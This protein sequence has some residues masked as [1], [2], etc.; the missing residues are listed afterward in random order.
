VDPTVNGLTIDQ[1]IDRSLT[2][3]GIKG[4]LRGAVTGDPTTHTVPKGGGSRFTWTVVDFPFRVTAFLGPVEA[5]Y[6]IGV[7]ITLRIVDLSEDVNAGQSGQTF[8]VAA[9]DDLFVYVRNQGVI[10]GGNTGTILVA[11]QAY[12]VFTLRNGVVYGKGE[13]ASFAE[14]LAT[15]EKHFT[16]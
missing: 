10:G 1:K 7:A 3:P 9:G 5:P 15:F 8:G 6:P 14:P 13:W 16:H 2:L 11:S 12:D 4:V